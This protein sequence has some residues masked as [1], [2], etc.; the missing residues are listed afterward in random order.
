MRVVEY[1]TGAVR[2][3]I[4]VVV[5]ASPVVPER[6]VG[7][8]VL[9]LMLGLFRPISCGVRAPAIDAALFRP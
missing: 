7:L 2:P 8:T 9:E 1:Y 5:S 3:L 4:V 6:P